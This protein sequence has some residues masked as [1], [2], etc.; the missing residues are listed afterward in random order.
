MGG[1]SVYLTMVALSALSNAE[2]ERGMPEQ[3]AA[4]W[5]L[6]LQLYFDMDVQARTAFTAGLRCRRR[7][8]PPR[9]GRTTRS[10]RTQAVL[11]APVGP[12]GR[13][14]STVG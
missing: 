2:A 6:V 14:R 12:G 9:P 3:A 13:R 1:S 5:D 8:D 10:S 11:F 7:P 4:T